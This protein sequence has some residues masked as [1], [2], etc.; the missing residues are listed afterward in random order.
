MLK[1]RDI[2][3]AK[4][5]TMSPDFTIRDAMEFLATKRISGAPVV[6]NGVV[7]GLVSATD[8]IAFAASQPGVRSEPASD[9]V[10]WDE[11]GDAEDPDAAEETGGYFTDML[12]DAG[13]EVDLR[14]RA[15]D[16]ALTTALD[17]HT[18]AEVMTERIHSLPSTTGVGAAA[19][20][21][22]KFRIHRLL[23][24]DRSELVG[25]VSLS[26][27]AGA[28]ADHRLTNRTYVFNRNGRFDQRA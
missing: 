11:E 10:E 14:F 16:R 15:G 13:D 24:M 1:L 20:Y 9:D 6:D 18:V 21:M 27:I 8:L 7:I 23:V 22:R 19:D 5:L 4:V 2:M 28:V 26:D 12:A 17:D 25:I 3:T